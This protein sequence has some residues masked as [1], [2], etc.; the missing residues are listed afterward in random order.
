MRSI[1]LMSRYNFQTCKST[2]LKMVPRTKNVIKT[3]S[4]CV[5]GGRYFC[6]YWNVAIFTTK[7]SDIS[8]NSMPLV[9]ASGPQRPYGHKTAADSYQKSQSLR[10][11]NRGRRGEKQRKRS[12]L[13]DMTVHH[14]ASYVMDCHY[15]SHPTAHLSL[16]D[17]GRHMISVKWR[18]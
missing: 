14:F 9:C 17:C 12:M 13:T 18:S 8:I 4:Y 16:P 2:C 3:V 11:M 1:F 10:K 6:N 15:A 7:S 5:L